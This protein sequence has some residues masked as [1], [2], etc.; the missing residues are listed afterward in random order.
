MSSFSEYNGLVDFAPATVASQEPVD[1]MTTR[2]NLINNAAHLV[3]SSTQQRSNWISV[4]G[5]SN[6]TAGGGTFAPPLIWVSSS[7]ADALP[8]VAIGPFP[9]TIGPDGLPAKL[10]LRV[11]AAVANGSGT[12]LA[13]VSAY[14]ARAPERAG[15]WDGTVGPPPTPGG[16]DVAQMTTASATP[17]WLTP[18]PSYVQI[19]DPS[20]AAFGTRQIST[21][22]VAG[23][24]ASTATA[25]MAE[26]TIWTQSTDPATPTVI[27]G[28]Y[29]REFVG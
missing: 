2:D 11:A 28:V 25:V 16:P 15:R 17:V 9:I 23:G 5:R 13:H 10:V 22:L 6:N 19:T 21:P 29:A 26:L 7:Y 8:V 20:E 3:Q 18:S 12:V 1:V 4:A 27:H 24:N 14:R